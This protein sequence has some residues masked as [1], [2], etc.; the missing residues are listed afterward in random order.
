METGMGVI[1]FQPRPPQAQ[2]AVQAPRPKSW[3]DTWVRPVEW[4]DEHL[5]DKFDAWDRIDKAHWSDWKEEAKTCYDVTAGR[6]WDE[7]AESENDE[8]KLLAISINKVDSTVSAISGSEMTNQQDVKYYP[9]ETSTRGPDGQLQDV[10]VNEI[11]TA[12]AEWVRD[13]C[14]ARDEESEAFRDVLICGL[15]VTDTSMEYETDPDGMAVIRRCDPLEFRIGKAMRPNAADA[16]RIAREKPFGKDEA[17][18]KFGI[19]EG[20]SASDYS[21]GTHENNP[22]WAYKSG[23]G[24]I[25]NP[26]DIIITEYQWWEL[27]KIHR[28]KNP[29]TGQIE[30]LSEDEFNQVNEALGGMLDSASVRLR[31]YYRAFRTGDKL[32][33]VSPLPDDEFTYKFIT[34]KW[35]RNR[36]VWYGVVRAMVDPQR[37]LN[38]QISQI[39][40]IVDTNAK[41]GLLAET[42]AFENDDDA[43]NDWAASDSI[44]WVKQGKLQS[45]AVIPKP[46]AP[47][48]PGLDKLLA[49]ANEAVPGV[50]GVN[51]E[52]LGVIDREQAGVVDITRKEA[53]Y[54]VLKA[55]FNSLRRYR[56]MHGRHLLKLI[57]KYMSDGRLIRIIGRSGNVQYLPLIRQPETIKYDV[58]VDEAPTGPN[59]KDKVFQFLT[60][61]GGPIMAKL[62]LPPQVWMKFLE[63]SPLPTSL[64][65]EVTKMVME[66]P[67]PSDPNTQK[68]QHEQAMGQMK[69]QMDQAKAQSDAQL[70]AAQMQADVQIAQMKAAME[71]QTERQKAD[72]QAQ[73]AARQAELDAAIARMKAE[74]DAQVEAEKMDRQMALE[75]WKAEQAQAMAEKQFAFEARLQ[76]MEQSFNQRLAQ[77]QADHDQTIQAKK[78][79]T[80]FGGQVG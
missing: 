76:V 28:V 59:Q 41:G 21:P 62:N 48:P 67:P 79:S 22:N 7:D 39:Q 38:K 20:G 42:G 2:T 12:A 64:V 51:Q 46:I 54:G 40:R 34:G 18:D 37:L 50:S 43:E 70:Q 77:K 58:I 8:K 49:I 65:A 61:F 27:E 55:F 26:D 6:Q 36:K 78:A 44:V 56:K 53:A 3:A 30:E 72:A 35:D 32:I 9:R 19:T 11:F 80:E 4:T 10:V 45:G 71:A 73:Q 24:Q 47:T 31:R 29:Q 74:R 52:M 57:A 60:M 14:D 13:E 5:I 25:R 69:L 15:G 23:S 16:Q 75:Q 17:K 1:T 63:F 66:M 68:A 33:E